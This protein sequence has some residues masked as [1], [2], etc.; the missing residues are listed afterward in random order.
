MQKFLLKYFCILIRMTL[1]RVFHTKNS[2][3][4]KTTKKRRKKSSFAIFYQWRKKQERKR[5]ENKMKMISMLWNVIF[6]FKNFVKVFWTFNLL[7]KWLRERIHCLNTR[8]TKWVVYW[9]IS[10]VIQMTIDNI[11]TFNSKQI[12]LWFWR[13]DKLLL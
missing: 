2:F 11:T 13:L 3:I 7:F 12:N 9:T 5:F 10:S 1:I 8:T 6:L 4:W